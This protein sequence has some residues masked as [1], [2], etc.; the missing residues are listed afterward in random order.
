MEPLGI[1]LTP[2][3]VD[4]AQYKLRE[5]RRD[6]DMIID[7]FGQSLSPGNEQREYWGS[8]S[9]DREGSQNYAGI[10]NPAIDKLIDKVIFAPDRDTLVAATKA[11][12]R[13]LLWNHYVIPQWISDADR[14]VYWDRFGRPA[15]MPEYDF[16]FPTVWWWDQAKADRIK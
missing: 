6:F 8:T 4:D 2:C 7:G 13:A 16:G 12:D 15:K 11:L 5:D 9:A 10:K 14:Y 3:V 1:K